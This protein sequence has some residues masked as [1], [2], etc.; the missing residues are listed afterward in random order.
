[1]NDK[2][3]SARF[4]TGTELDNA[5]AAALGCGQSASEAAE[6]AK[7]AAEKASLAQNYANATYQDATA[8]TQAVADAEAHALAAAASAEEAKK[9]AA[10]GGGGSGGGGVSSWNDLTD[11]PFY[12]EFLTEE[13]LSVAS[14]PFDNTTSGYALYTAEN[15]YY[16]MTPGRAYTVTWAGEEYQCEAKAFEDT[17]NLSSGV[18]LGEVNMY[19]PNTPSGNN[20]PFGVACIRY[21]G[22]LEVTY[23]LSHNGVYNGPVEI[24]FE[25]EVVKTIDPKYLPEGIGSGGGVKHW[26]DL[27]GRPFYSEFEA[28]VDTTLEID[29]GRGTGVLLDPIGLVVG[30]EYT[31]T[32]NGTEYVCTAQAVDAE[33]IPMVVVGD[34]GMMMGGA[35]TG[36][37]FVIAE[38][39]PEVA[40][41]MG[42]AVMIVPVD[43]S[44]S[45]TIVIA[46]ETPKT[47][48]P[49]YL[50]ESLQFGSEQREKVLL[51][52]ERYFSTNSLVNLTQ[53][54]DLVAG[55]TY[56]VYWAGV[57]YKCVAQYADLDDKTS[58]VGLGNQSLQNKDYGFTSNDEPFFIGAFT[59]DKG[60]ES[61]YYQ[62]SIWSAEAKITV[63]VKITQ[64]YEHVTP[65]EAKYLQIIKRENGDTLYWDGDLD[66]RVLAT[67]AVLGLVFARVSDKVPTLD[68]FAKGFKFYTSGGAGGEMP[69]DRMGLVGA[70]LFSSLAPYFVVALE[71][72]A[73]LEE[74]TFPKKGIYFALSVDVRMESLT[75]VGYTGFVVE[76]INPRY[77]PSGSARETVTLTADLIPEDLENNMHIPVPREELGAA[78][79]VLNNGGRVFGTFRGKPVEIVDL[80]LDP[81]DAFDR[82]T[83]KTGEQDTYLLRYPIYIDSQLELYGDPSNATLTTPKVERKDIILRASDDS[84]RSFRITVNTE[85]VLTATEVT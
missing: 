16:D 13:I 29:P 19:V 12:S 24:R 77:L 47:I 68:D 44:P 20:E 61:E 54:T 67:G 43:G 45:V 49:K 58:L 79:N 66:G 5:L 1:M 25:G 52:E 48:D 75:I 4:K 14:L 39:P 51:E 7:L 50:P 6:S 76:R 80:W 83:F 30:Q 63:S 21:E 41:E 57:K 38:I 42:A 36:E 81:V 31:V 11:K 46:I 15:T 10:S 32:W 35:S 34:F 23:I 55:E 2:Y 64:D 62:T 27:E 78:V 56:N 74:V 33:G 3:C 69:G 26:D 59:F 73:V 9:A 82:V 65:L 37:P 71:D 40:A 84:T 60:L 72:G 70:V 28:L 85:G 18:V 53:R 8:A 22:S 17:E